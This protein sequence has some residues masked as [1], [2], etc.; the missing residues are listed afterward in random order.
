MKSRKTLIAVTLV[1]IGI[2]VAIVVFKQLR[3][4]SSPLSDG[5]R[6]QSLDGSKEHTE[7]DDKKVVHISEAEMKEF[8]VEVG[9]AG[10]GKIEIQLSL[11]GEV[12]ANADRLVHVVPRVSGIVRDVRKNIGDYVRTGELLAVLDSRE[13]ADAKASFLA[14]WEREKLARANFNREED[15]WKK[16]ISAE[17]DY[18]EAK[19]V[20][21]EALIELRSSEQKLHAIG[22]SDAYLTR[23]PEQPEVAFTKYSLTAPSTGTI[24]QK[25]I[26]RGEVLRED[27]EAFVI[28]DL[29]SVWVNISVYQKD[30]IFIRKGQ[31][32]TISAGHEIPDVQGEI[33]YVGPLVGEQTRTGIARVVLPNTKGQWRPGLFITARLTVKETDVAVAVPKTALQVMDGQNYIFIRTTEGF[34]PIPVTIGKNDDKRVEIISGLTTGQEF[35]EDGVF[36]LKAQLLKSEFG[37]E[38]GH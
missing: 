2:I 1:L 34:E 6:D 12:V 14:A 17:Q 29:S 5:N 4:S 36:A 23:L 25:H 38:H 7:S 35:A 9:A 31:Q 30:M 11:P 27:S 10:P 13:L 20:L 18:L 24:L 37:D 22:F 19:R 32:V 16:K 26:A 15:L 28:A 21:A 3:T 8:G 33:S